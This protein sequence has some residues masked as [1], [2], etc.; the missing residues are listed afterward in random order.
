MKC[1]MVLSYESY[2]SALEEKQR[3]ENEV[4]SIPEEMNQKFDRIM[5]WIQQNAKLAQGK[6]EAL[7]QKEL[8]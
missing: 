1:K 6:P 4:K 7:L 8:T 3:R 2:E 5:S